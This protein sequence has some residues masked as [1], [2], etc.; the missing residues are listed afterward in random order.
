MEMAVKGRTQ[1]Q[2]EEKGWRKKPLLCVTEEVKEKLQTTMDDKVKKV[3]QKQAVKWGF[4]HRG[5][6]G[7]TTFLSQIATI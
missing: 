6:C 4:C 7:V 1:W 3:K 2:K 5:S